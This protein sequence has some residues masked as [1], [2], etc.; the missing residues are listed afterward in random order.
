[1]T[2]SSYAVPFHSEETSLPLA[3]GISLLLKHPIEFRLHAELHTRYHVQVTFM[4]CL[5][6]IHSH[7]VA[8]GVGF[9]TPGTLVSDRSGQVGMKKAQVPGGL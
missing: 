7:F 5:F 3:Q 6:Y 4:Y 8:F 9:L 1:M 2:L